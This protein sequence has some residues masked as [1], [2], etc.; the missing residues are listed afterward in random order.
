MNQSE[1]TSSDNQIVWFNSEL[2]PDFRPEWFNDAHW[3][4]QNAVIGQAFGRG[5]TTFFSYAGQEMV[6]RHYLRGGLPGKLL[7]DQYLY[8][9]L[10][11]TRS[12][13][14]MRL[15]MK[16]L[17]LGLPVPEPV[18]ARVCKHGLVYRSD[19]VLLKIPGAIDIHNWLLE[20]PLS[21]N[22]WQQIGFL[23][24]QFHLYQV[25]H[26]DLNIHNIMTDDNGKL[27]LIDFDKCAIKQGESWKNKNLERLQRSLNK[28]AAA[29][30]GYHF[31]M[32]KWQQLM[33]GYEAF[34]DF[35]EKR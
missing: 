5:T 23:I 24:A 25:Y 21:D 35:P 3:R 2:V 4:K 26:H 29:H 6:L 14:E 33:R 7:T 13:R 15:L 16:M 10:Q 20:R 17:E 32:E 22:Q 8:T 11:S 30:P 18:A 19:I 9:G 31:S 27:W 12:W 28:E 1:I 34:P